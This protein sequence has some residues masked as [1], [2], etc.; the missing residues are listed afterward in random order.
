MNTKTI[1][2]L[3][4]TDLLKSVWGSAGRKKSNLDNTAKTIQTRAD[5]GLLMSGQELCT[6]DPALYTT[7]TEKLI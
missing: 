4:K 7:C 2:Q 6:V 5:G 1:F 3:K